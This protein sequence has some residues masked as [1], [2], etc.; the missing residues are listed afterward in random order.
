[1]LILGSLMV[2]GITYPTL[3]TLELRKKKPFIYLLALI[4]MLGFLLLF[5]QIVIFVAFVTYLIL[6]LYDGIRI[7]SR[8]RKLARSAAMPEKTG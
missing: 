1:M 2:T 5:P 4:L 7:D 3:L 6:G 8:E